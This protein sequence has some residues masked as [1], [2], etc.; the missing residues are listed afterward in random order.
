M[1]INGKDV[2]CF[3]VFVS[4]KCFM[5]HVF[6]QEVNH[7]KV[8]EISE[9]TEDTEEYILGVIKDIINVFS[10]KDFIFC[11]YN[12]IHFLVSRNFI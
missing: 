5:V 10:Y 6:N 12:N 3:K 4:P 9:E 11:G 1:K 8:Y 2:I 7:N